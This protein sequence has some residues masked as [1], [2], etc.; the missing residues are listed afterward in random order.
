[1][2]AY[3]EII[4][5]LLLTTCALTTAATASCAEIAFSSHSDFTE[6]N[7]NI[8]DT[9]NVN[10]NTLALEVTLSPDAQRR[11]QE[12]SSAA[13]DQNLTVVI[14]GKIVNT[15]RVVN[16][17]D[18]PQLQITVSR[19]V[20]LELLP[21]LIGGNFG[22]ATPNESVTTAP[23]IPTPGPASIPEPLLASA[24]GEVQPQQVAAPVVSES[25]PEV[26]A[27]AIVAAAATMAP[28]GSGDQLSAS[29]TQHRL[30]RRP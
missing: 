8:K 20:A 4:A 22:A 18:S 21:G 11:M 27:P 26:A 5:A 19:Q 17:L 13:L 30:T 15:A 28:P 7:L 3:W 9:F 10:P 23:V 1:M 16:V 29:V 25:P 2:R 6:I 24:P 14:N 12:A